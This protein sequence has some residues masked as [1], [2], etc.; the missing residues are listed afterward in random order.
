MTNNFTS[1]VSQLLKDNPIN[2]DEFWTNI[3]TKRNSFYYSLKLFEVLVNPRK[4]D[5]Y[6][7]HLERMTSMLMIIEYFHNIDK[8]DPKLVEDYKQ[9]FKKVIPVSTYAARWIFEMFSESSCEEVLVKGF[10]RVLAD[11][12]LP[13][14]RRE[15]E[16][17]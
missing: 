5:K 12:P 14:W 7:L 4:R 16:E 13:K 1:I 10:L 3:E 2:A 17:E 15:I 8:K 6:S 11:L 9:L